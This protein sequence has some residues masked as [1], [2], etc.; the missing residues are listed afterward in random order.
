MA[1]DFFKTPVGTQL[2]RALFFMGLLPLVLFAREIKLMKNGDV[3]LAV[4]LCD[5]PG[6]KSFTDRLHRLVCIGWVRPS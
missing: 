5:D 3:P 6:Q 1:K 4:L 2:R